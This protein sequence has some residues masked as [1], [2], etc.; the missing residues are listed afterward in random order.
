M[1]Y[2]QIN[3]I[4]LVLSILFTAGLLAIILVEVVR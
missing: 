3:L 2:K 1:S 4:V